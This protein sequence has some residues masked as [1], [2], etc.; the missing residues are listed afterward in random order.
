M[1]NY[2]IEEVHISDIKV[3][4][5]VLIKGELCTVCRNNI[6]RGGFCGDT[7]FGNSYVSGRVPVKKAIIITA[8]NKHLYT[9]ISDVE[10]IKK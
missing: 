7:L 1:V 3:G 6:K 4:D 8:F 10:W 9:K 2:A 5:T